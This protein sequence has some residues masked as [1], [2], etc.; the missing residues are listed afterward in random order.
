M[1][2]DSTQ[3]HLTV[4]SALLSLF[5][6]TYLIA[7]AHGG[8]PGVDLSVL[9]WVTGHRSARVTTLAHAA[10]TGSP[11]STTRHR[12]SPTVLRSRAAT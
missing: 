9:R 10:S 2:S 8:R 5:I 11:I 1:T 6:V 7:T 3:R 4:S 12:P